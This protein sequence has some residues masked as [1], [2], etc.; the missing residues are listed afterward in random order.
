MNTK[1]FGVAI[2]FLALTLAGCGL[3]EGMNEKSNGHIKTTEFPTGAEGKMDRDA[4]LPSW[5]PD[6]AKSV[7]EAIRTTGTERILRFTNAD[8]P[9]T[10]RP[11]VVVKTAATLTADWWPHGTEGKADQVCDQEWH[12]VKANDAVYAFKPET[13]DQSDA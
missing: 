4:Q 11:G 12:V 6:E 10:C 1:T 13:I 2:G 8:L 3:Q 7:T 5:V 9:T